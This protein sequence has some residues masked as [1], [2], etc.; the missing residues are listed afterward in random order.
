MKS[1]TSDNTKV[2]QEYV[3]LISS[4]MLIDTIIKML[5]WK[6]LKGKPSSDQNPSS[7]FLSGNLEKLSKSRKQKL[8]N[9]DNNIQSYRIKV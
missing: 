2:N 1:E 3:S 5:H 9:S 7:I 4:H 6:C 8:Y